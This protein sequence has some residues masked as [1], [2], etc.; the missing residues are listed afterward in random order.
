MITLNQTSGDSKPSPRPQVE[1]LLRTTVGRILHLS[2]TGDLPLFTWTLG[3]PQHTLATVLETLALPSWHAE[4]IPPS[5]YAVIEKMVPPTFDTLRRSLFQFR[6][7]SLDA[8]H[9][10]HLARAITAACFGSRQ[11][12]QDLGLKDE[13][14]L[15]TLLAVFFQPLHRKNKRNTKWKRFL[16]S[17]LHE[18]PEQWSSIREMLLKCVMQRQ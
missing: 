16:L 17:A 5:E 11:L 4:S 13:E 1:N 10:D 14:A 2:E 6:T 15:S 9:A 8:I 18:T 3:L 7:P 12:W